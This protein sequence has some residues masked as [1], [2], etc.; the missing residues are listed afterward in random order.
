MKQIVLTRIKNI[1]LSKKKKQNT[2]KKEKSID[3]Q[4]L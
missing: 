4:N 1:K 3:I 2:V